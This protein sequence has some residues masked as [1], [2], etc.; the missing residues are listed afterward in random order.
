MY[1][2]LLFALLLGLFTQAAVAAESAGVTSARQPVERLN[3][4]L[5]DVMKNSARLKYQGRYKKLEPV[6]KDVFQF[7]AVAQIAL[8]SHWKKL[9]Q[10]QKITFIG[11]LTNLSVATYAAQFNEYA[12]EKFE[13]QSGEETKADRVTLRYLMV[14]PNEKPIKFEYIV[15]QF[16]GQWQIINIIVDGI[17]DLAL[18]KAQ[19]TSVIDREGFDKLVA[20][21]S[22]KVTDYAK[23]NK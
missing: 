10:T 21:L 12:G 13:Y 22:Q 7:E 19:Y 17:S 18:K 5:I 8:G 20:K 14:A 2:H 4:V 3:D 15:N 16:S 1:I 9:E 23:K 6:V 11:V